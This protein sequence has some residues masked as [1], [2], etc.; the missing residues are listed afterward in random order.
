MREYK[1]TQVGYI[2][3]IAWGAVILFICGLNIATGFQPFTLIVPIVML[4]LFGA[5]LNI[6]GKGRRRGDYISI[7]GGNYP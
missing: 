3:V 6:D 2:H 5:V 1:H 4:I 7:R